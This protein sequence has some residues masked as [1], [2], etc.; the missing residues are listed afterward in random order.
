MLT[1]K[2]AG[3]HSVI[4][5]LCTK[6][7]V[8][9]KAGSAQGTVKSEMSEAQLRSMSSQMHTEDVTT[10]GKQES[11]LNEALGCW[12]KEREGST[13]LCPPGCR[14]AS[15]CVILDTGFKRFKKQEKTVGDV[16]RRPLS[17]RLQLT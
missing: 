16:K 5:Q 7:C 4:Q 11:S 17:H 6:R 10:Q 1:K 12:L 14:D 8:K 13:Q 3:A 15:K 2:K 9:Y